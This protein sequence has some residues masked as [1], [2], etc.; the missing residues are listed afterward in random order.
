MLRHPVQLTS[1]EED[2]KQLGLLSEEGTPSP[3]QKRA[4]AGE[5][6][7][8]KTGSRNVGAQSE[9]DKEE[10]EDGNTTVPGHEG[11]VPPK[12]SLPTTPGSQKE[13]VVGG[14]SRRQ[15]LRGEASEKDGEEDDDEDD[16]EDEKKSKKDDEDD[17]EKEESVELEGTSQVQE[18]I[19]R[20][21]GDKKSSKTESRRSGRGVKTES[22][23]PSGLDKV[24]SL[25][26]DVNNIM[27][28]I[29]DS[30]RGDAVRAFANSS[31]IAEMLS[32]GF[33]QFAKNYED[34]DLEAAA[35]AFSSLSEDASSIA[36]ALEEGE[37]VDPD[38]LQTEFRA[39]MDALMDGLD[40]YSDVVEADSELEEEE[41]TEAG[42]EQTEE[43]EETEEAVEEAKEATKAT[44]GILSQRTEAYF[45]QGKSDPK[46]AKR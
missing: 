43:E 1:L 14:D 2:F 24:A 32:K 40:L 10:G 33:G 3:P 20:L 16:D 8:T 18:A 19:S 12:A 44:G 29:D 36:S 17:I 34:A 7:H 6:G 5:P 9:G 30:R 42:E 13:S 25:I 31:I 22:R 26:E 46:G 11:A 38:A 41:E 23:K 39:Q 35:E 27:E 15:R 21:R 37:E 28:S 45:R 4:P